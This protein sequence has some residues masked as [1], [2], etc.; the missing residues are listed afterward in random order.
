MKFSFHT[1]EIT[2]LQTGLCGLMCF[3]EGLGEGQIYQALDKA[4]DGLLSRVVAEEQFKGK[5]GQSLLLHTHGRIGASRLLLVGAGARKDFS[6]PDLRGFG[7]RVVKA[8]AAASVK[9]VTAVM[10]Y[11]EGVVQERAAQFLAEGALS[12]A[13]RFNKYLTGEKKPDTVE[14]L[15]IA[16]SSDNVDASRV[17]SLRR[18][19]QRGEQV[20][21]GVALAR[22]LINEPAGEM[23]PRKMAE[24]AQRVAKQHGLEIKVLGPKECEK[25]GMGMY[26]AVAQGSD[27]EPRFIHLT[28]HPKTK[29]KPAAK[30]TI[31]LV[32]KGVTF[33]S[34]G[35]S[36][37]P[38]ASM[39]DM[40][41]DMSGAAAVIAAIG[42]LAD[43]GVPYEVHAI[44]A[45]T[46][47]MPSGKSYKLGD[48]LKSMSGKTVEIN[49]TDAEGRLTL[50][51]AIWYIKQEA[52]PDEIFD[53]ATLTGAC[54]VAL[55]PHI[56]GV[57][58]NDLSLVERWLSAAKLAGED[59]W[60]LP[61]PEKLKEQ[62]K[63][64]VAD[65]RNTGERWGGALTAGLFLK[66]FVG[67]TP[68]VHCDIAGPAALDKENGHI[69][70]GGT[71]F[72][73]ATIVEYLAARD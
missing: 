35:L 12:A 58:G 60:H 47:N 3:E 5:K 55:G 32:G 50:G 22:D 59:M 18:G 9:S 26:L 4:L 37:K 40:K 43:L 11:T 24:V 45:C 53:F 65:M 31:A 21:E 17:D 34:G 46:E 1:D 51:D 63:S 23:T 33:D 36:L 64:D 6:P 25:L 7:A 57:M 30:R 13:Y 29:G 15:K 44:A 69:P 10:P 8:G 61:L 70:K 16:M 27:E 56:A 19:V 68:W 38:S 72:A 52:K 48:V 28:Y 66:E 14:E 62:L 39:E 54:M 41:V 2:K 42:V 71:G 20:A 49:N 67:D 73:V